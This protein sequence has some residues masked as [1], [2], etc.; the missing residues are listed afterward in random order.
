[1]FVKDYM[2]GNPITITPDAGIGDAFKL[3]KEHSVRRLPVMSGEQ[4]VGIVTKQDLLKSSPS[5]ATSLSEINQLFVFQNIHVKEIMT[6]NVTVISADTILEEA[7]VIMQE[8]K[9]A[10]LPVMDQD[11]LVGMITESDIFKAFID[12]FGFNYPSIRL[13]LEVEDK[14]GMLSGA[15]QIIKGMGINIT[16][17]IVRKLEGQRANIIFRLD[18]TD[19]AEVKQALEKEQ[20]KIVHIA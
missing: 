17:V 7:A 11:K 15:A 4:I 9:I 2:S 13:T 5:P 20:Y 12:I 8:K 1:M 10:S 16:S 18:T 6:K 3:M 19:A 14:V